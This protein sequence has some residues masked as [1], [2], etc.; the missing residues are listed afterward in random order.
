MTDAC[1]GSGTEPPSQWA[2][3]KEADLQAWLGAVEPL[4]LFWLLMGPR[5]PH[6]GFQFTTCLTFTPPF[7]QL[8][9]EAEKRHE[10]SEAE[11]RHEKCPPY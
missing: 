7:K 4:L 8:L 3:Q 5:I 10:K 1:K 11:K 9:S 6:P 2:Q